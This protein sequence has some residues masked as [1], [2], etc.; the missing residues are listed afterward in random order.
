ME[1]PDYQRS[2]VL[3]PNEFLKAEMEKLG[4]FGD[5]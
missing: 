4:M 1:D 2:E 5:Q 3:T